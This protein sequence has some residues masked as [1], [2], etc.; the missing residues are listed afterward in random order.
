MNYLIGVVKM[1]NYC[2]YSVRVKGNKKAG[3]MV[4]ESM[5]CLDNKEIDPDQPGYAICFSGNCKW[6]VNYGVEDELEAVDLNSM[7]EDD[8]IDQAENFID[9]SLRAKSE[10]FDC[11]I[12]VHYWSDESGFNQFDHYVKGQVVKKRKIAYEDEP[13]E[14]DWIKTEFVGHEGEYDESVD[15]EAQNEELM[16]LL[17]GLFNL[18][19]EN[20]SVDNSSK[21]T[22][23][24]KFVSSELNKLYAGKKNNDMFKWTFTSGKTAKTDDWTMKIP[25]GFTTIR[26]FDGKRAFTLVPE[27][28]KGYNPGNHTVCILPGVKGTALLAKEDRWIPHLKARKAS[29]ALCHVAFSKET[30]Q[31]DLGLLGEMHTIAWD[32]MSALIEI[33][34]TDNDSYSFQCQIDRGDGSYLIRIQTTSISEAQKYDLLDSIEKML[35][36]V[37]FN[38]PNSICPSRFLIEEDRVYRDLVNGKKQKFE[39]AIDQISLACTVTYL[40]NIN[41]LEYM[42]EYGIIDLNDKRVLDELQQVHNDTIEV[43]DYCYKL[44]DK[45]IKKLVDNNIK[46][47]LP[48]VLT[49]MQD[50]FN[51]YP[52][53]TLDSQTITAPPTDDLT[54]I[55]EGWKKLGKQYGVTLSD[56]DSSTPASGKQQGQKSSTKSAPLSKQEKWEQKKKSEIESLEN[57]RQKLTEDLKKQY[58]EKLKKELSEIESDY[59]EKS[60]MLMEKER[61]YTLKRDELANEL[62]QTIWLKLFTRN[63]LK[64]NLEFFEKQLSDNKEQQKHIKDQR[65]T[66]RQKSQDA[67]SSS[68]NN[69]QEEVLNKIPTPV[70]TYAT[71]ENNERMINAVIS[72][73]NNIGRPMT[74]SEIVGYSGLKY[75]AV[76]GVLSLLIEKKVVT[77][78]MDRHQRV[79]FLC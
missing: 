60:E 73:F 46:S 28:E 75:T 30:G 77:E 16:N 9:Y 44:V 58:E 49:K 43:M 11:E 59:A 20:A 71:S 78:F 13:A 31:G 4:F 79:Y 42:D 51:G 64:K 1:A 70:I 7:T 63:K 29:S 57:K 41:K 10:A 5:P 36:T 38:S 53:T 40:G 54:K 76:Y 3:L 32:D 2:D 66:K 21:N 6:S 26:P 22:N 61:E 24:N 35:H 39:E 33:Y 48:D 65:L 47:V 17:G 19:K 72:T 69:I 12:L 67:Y 74:A 8:I 27:S 15:G 14:F 45:V 50:L 23:N 34:D 18:N 37:K 62:S 68:M 55:K 25:D 52:K 56:P